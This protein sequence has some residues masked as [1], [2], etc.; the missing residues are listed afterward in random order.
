MRW[1]TLMFLLPLLWFKWLIYCFHTL[2]SRLDAHSLHPGYCSCHTLWHFNLRQHCQVWLGNEFYVKLF[3][4]DHFGLEQHNSFF[5]IRPAAGLE[6]LRLELSGL[7][8]RA[9]W[10]STNFLCGFHRTDRTSLRL[11]LKKKKENIRAC[12]H[13]T[14][15]TQQILCNLK[16]LQ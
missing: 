1:N 16:K 10:D 14:W 8:S 9:T 4:N 7:A 2:W 3:F 12:R 11:Q 15:H 13:T 5:I 6:L